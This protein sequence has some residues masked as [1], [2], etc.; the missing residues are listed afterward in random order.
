MKMMPGHGRFPLS[1][2]GALVLSVAFIVIPFMD[3]SAIGLKKPLSVS[4]S[5]DKAASTTK[6]HPK[7]TGVRSTKLDSPSDAIEAKLKGAVTKNVQT[8]Q[9]TDEAVTKKVQ[10]SADKASTTKLNP[11]DTGVRST[12]KHDS[13]SDVIEEK[14]E[15]A[16]TKNVQTKQKTDGAV[17]KTVPTSKQ[18]QKR[19]PLSDL[20]H[21]NDITGDVQF[22]LDFAII[23]HPKCGTDKQMHWISNHEEIQMYSYE[24]RSLKD[25][26]P[27]ELVSL[28]YDLPE[29][30]EYIRGY[31]A[32]RDVHVKKALGSLD[33]YWPKTKLMVGLR[34]PI[35]WFN[36]YYNYRSRMGWD[37]APAETLV[38][39]HMPLEVFYHK[40]LA[41]MG[42]TNPRGNP[43][44]AR[45]LGIK[46]SNSQDS[47][48][49]AM[50]NQVLLY[51]SSQ[52]FDANRTRAEIYWK[53][54]TNYI[55]V[56][57]PF[58]PP[59]RAERS[60]NK[61]FAIDICDA[62]YAHVRAELLEIGTAAAD[63][64]KNYFM[65]LPEVIVPSPEY[66]VEMLD[67]WREDPCETE[68]Q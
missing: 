57:R 52:P 3:L 66:F 22:L 26:K 54:L 8:K 42:K 48:D 59:K 49:L 11:K 24:V 36:S 62:K 30:E 40:N 23:G 38:G 64:I 31:K 5:S 10:S 44:E 56:K 39:K 13:S 60:R 65:V 45:L 20:I 28:M 58:V 29:G 15:G 2:R 53:E 1:R 9:K 46:G 37:M 34:H 12:I 43:K 18:S 25:G 21:N 68:E 33:K 32:P 7:D 16:V 19:P 55:D 17:T 4:Q 47:N 14:L 50:S 61:G 27:A 6:L 51:D 35:K 41:Q 67:T 63:W